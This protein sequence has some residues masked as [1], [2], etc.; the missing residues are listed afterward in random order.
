MQI[1]VLMRSAAAA[2]ALALGTLALA[3]AAAAEAALPSYDDTLADIAATWGLVPAFIRAVP[4]EQL[5]A[6]WQMQKSLEA[7]SN[8]PAKYKALISV[9][10][11][12]QI[13]CQYCTWLDSNSAYLAGATPD[14][15]AEAVLIAGSTRMWSAF[16]YGT[17]ADMATI[18]SE[19]AP[20]A[21]A[22]EAARM[23][24]SN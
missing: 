5:P 20:M 21:E 1:A 15:I 11:A 18:R 22:A 14:E 24:A 16:L 12:S 3:P 17:Q 4:H 13:P 23:K 2:A 10:V 9:A 19:F 6:L 7:G 8:I